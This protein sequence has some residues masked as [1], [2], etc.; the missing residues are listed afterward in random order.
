M[1]TQIDIKTPDTKVEKTGNEIAA[2]KAPLREPLALAPYST[3]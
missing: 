2:H 1:S 3:L